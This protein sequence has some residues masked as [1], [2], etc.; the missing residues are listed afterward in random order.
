LFIKIDI[1]ATSSVG[2]L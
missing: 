2:L 1:D